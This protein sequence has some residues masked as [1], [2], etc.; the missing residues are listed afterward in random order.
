MAGCTSFGLIGS[1]PYYSWITDDITSLSFFHAPLPKGHDY[2]AGSKEDMPCINDILL[3]GRYCFQND[4]GSFNKTEFKIFR[5]NFIKLGESLQAKGTDVTSGKITGITWTISPRKLKAIF[6]IA[7]AHA[8]VLDDTHFATVN[9][10]SQIISTLGK[11]DL[12]VFSLIWDSQLK[13][14]ELEGL[15]GTDVENYR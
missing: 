2:F 12:K 13:R 8:L 1:P 10:D 15:V 3:L 9:N 5:S 6:K 7:L 14:N 11:D 4:F